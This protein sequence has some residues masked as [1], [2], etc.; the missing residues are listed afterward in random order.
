VRHPAAGGDPTAHPQALQGRTRRPRAFGR[1][2][3]RCAR[4]PQPCARARGPGLRQAQTVHWT[5]CVRA[6]LLAAPE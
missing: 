1:P 3:A 2:P 6:Q 4:R 5:V